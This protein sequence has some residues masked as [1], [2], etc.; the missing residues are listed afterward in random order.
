MFGVGTTTVN[1]TATDL[2]GN[3]TGATFIVRVKPAPDGLMSGVGDVFQGGKRH[4][5]QFRVAQLWRYDFG[6][7]EYRSSGLFSNANRFEASAVN[8]N[9]FRPIQRSGP[10]TSHARRWTRFGLPAPAGGTIAPATPSRPSR[11]TTGSLADVRRHLRAHRQGFPRKCRGSG[12]RRAGQR[13]HPID[14]ARLLTH[15]ARSLHPGWLRAISLTACHSLEKAWRCFRRP[16]ATVSAHPT[17]DS[18]PTSRE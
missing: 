2:A 4:H 14:S 5:F 11:P 7:F 8:T 12:Q 13:Q 18:L 17:A 10:V 16:G 1:C 9:L 3:A 15:P 6:R